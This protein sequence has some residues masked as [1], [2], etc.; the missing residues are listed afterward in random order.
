MPVGALEAMWQDVELG[1]ELGGSLAEL[2]ADEADWVL[3]QRVIRGEALAVG[4]VA[5]YMAP[6][7]LESVASG[8]VSPRQLIRPKA[9]WQSARMVGGL[10]RVS[11]RLPGFLQNSSRSF[12]RTTLPS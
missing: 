2:I 7:A 4:D 11:P 3:G 8:M 6:E 1:L 9:Q 5:G 12:A 10:P